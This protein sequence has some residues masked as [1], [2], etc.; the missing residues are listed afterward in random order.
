MV[1]IDPAR[2]KNARIY[3]IEL[4]VVNEDNGLS[5]PARWS[6]GPFPFPVFGSLRLIAV[7]FRPSQ[8]LP[9]HARVFVPSL[10]RNPQ[11]QVQLRRMNRGRG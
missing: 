11:S 5:G 7:R 1:A 6:A 2:W 4:S 10:L 8:D 3:L 9:V